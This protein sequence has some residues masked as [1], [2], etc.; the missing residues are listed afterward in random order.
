M[1]VFQRLCSAAL[2]LLVVGCASL[3]PD[4]GREP[5]TAIADCSDT[6][7]YD[8]LQPLLDAKEGLPGFRTLGEGEE[9]FV[10]R[11]RLALAA[12]KSIDIQYYILHDDITGSALHNQMI[13]QAAGR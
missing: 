13:K 3:P 12:D 1:Y 8:Q 5:S 2:V 6:R 11:M 10:A 9:A 7:I 4:P